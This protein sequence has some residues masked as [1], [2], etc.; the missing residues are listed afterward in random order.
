MH[1]EGGSEGELN[2]SRGWGGF[3]MMSQ[4]PA[5]IPH[6]QVTSDVLSFHINNGQRQ[7]NFVIS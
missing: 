1:L 3:R 7:L 5:N 2:G 4:L 6:A